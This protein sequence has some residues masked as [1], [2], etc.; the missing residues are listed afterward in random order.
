MRKAYYTYM[1]AAKSGKLVSY[2]AMKKEIDLAKTYYY[3]AIKAADKAG[4]K[5]GSY[6][7]QLF[8]NKKLLTYAERYAL[9]V[10][11]NLKTPQTAFDQALNSGDV[12]EVIAAHKALNSKLYS[13]NKSTAQVYGAEARK[14]FNNQAKPAKAKLTSIQTEI[15]VYNAYEEMERYIE[16]SEHVK[17]KRKIDS[18]KA[19]VDK[20]RAKNSTF[21]KNIVKH[22]D[23]I[24]DELM[25]L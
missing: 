5:R 4:K 24:R 15:K 1:N 7:K 19:K 22:A 13:F 25:V 3:A 14:L 17:A 16:I 8:E 2:S 18:V 9:T 21:A 23:E 11:I 12:D 6:R 20:L 10:K